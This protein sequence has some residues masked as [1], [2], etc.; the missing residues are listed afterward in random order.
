MVIGSNP[1]TKEALSPVR[2]APPVPLGSCGVDVGDS[3]PLT[4]SRFELLRG[5]ATT[6]KR[7]ASAAS[8]RACSRGSVGGS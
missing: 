7:P 6:S 1:W 2:S 4:P 5:C 8:K 3:V